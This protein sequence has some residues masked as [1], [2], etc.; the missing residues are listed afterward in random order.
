MRHLGFA[1]SIFVHSVLLL[2]MIFGGP[3]F[4]PDE[5]DPIQIVD[6]Q[7][8]SAEEF[9]ELVRGP[10]PEPKTDALASL[11]PPTP[12]QP[13]VE[14]D[15]AEEAPP[16]NVQDAP[17]EDAPDAPSPLIFENEVQRDEAAELDIPAP[18]RVQVNP[19][20]AQPV[21][22]VPDR[23]PEADQPDAPP[24]E[25]EVAEAPE[26]ETPPEQ[27]QV[28]EAEQAPE[29]A[30][31]PQR[32]R[33]PRQVA[34]AEQPETEPER[35]EPQPQERA[36]EEPDP[37]Q[38]AEPQPRQ[39]QQAE[40]RRAPV[41]GPPLSRFERDGFQLA[42]RRCWNPPDPGG[43]DPTQLRVK[44]LLSMGRD[45]R[46]VGQAQLVEPQPPLSARQQAAIR[47]AAVAI[48]RCQPFGLPPAK[49]GY[50]QEIR[51][52]FDPLEGVLTQ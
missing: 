45:G 50:W 23:P 28:A 18:P 2:V 42:L 46:V 47:A 41:V 35:E 8:I 7:F 16:P 21:A 30:P 20:P 6:A 22:A 39:R 9:D 12:P 13:E 43:T 33:R 36:E 3:L 51:V 49:Y 26:E 4:T 27:E 44:L 14:R 10:T 40:R 32:A 37:E 19:A 5:D 52:T 31:R 25:E 15:P 34:E 48:Q 38:E 17:Y 29:A 24:V 11:A 1:I